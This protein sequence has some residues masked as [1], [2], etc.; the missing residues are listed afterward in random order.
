MQSTGSL[1]KLF[2]GIYCNIITIFTKEKSSVIITYP[3]HPLSI[4]EFNH[5]RVFLQ[6]AMHPGQHGKHSIGLGR[7]KTNLIKWGYHT[8]DPSC[9]CGTETQTMEHLLQ[10]PLLKTPCSRGDLSIFNDTAQKCMKLRV[11][12]I[13]RYNTDRHNNLS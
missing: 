11:S 6:K 13:R 10:C 5:L 1:T 2:N 12:T 7:T 8:G 3:T 4:W 9:N